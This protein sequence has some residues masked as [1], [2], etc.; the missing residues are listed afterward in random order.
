[1]KQTL[2]F[3]KT[4]IQGAC[5]GVLL[6]MTGHAMPAAAQGAEVVTIGTGATA[7]ANTPFGNSKAKAWTQSIYNASNFDLPAGGV[8]SA[9]A[10]QSKAVPA[11]FVAP[12]ITIYM[13]TTTMD[14]TSTKSDW[15]PMSDLT[16][17]YSG[18]EAQPLAAGWHTIELDTPYDYNGMENLVIAVLRDG[19]SASSSMNYGFTNMS[20]KTGV[21]M[22]M[23]DATGH[24]GTAAANTRN[25]MLANIKITVTPNAGCRPPLNLVTGLETRTSVELKWSKPEESIP[26]AYHIEYGEEGFV[27]GTGVTTVTADTTVTLRGLQPTQ[28]YDAYVRSICG[29]GDTSFAPASI[30]F[31]TVCTPQD[32]PYSDDFTSCDAYPTYHPAN[33]LPMCWAFPNLSATESDYPKIYVSNGRYLMMQT[34]G[35][36]EPAVAVLPVMATSVENSVLSFNCVKGNDITAQYGYI[37]DPNDASSFVPLGTISQE[38]YHRIDLEEDFETIPYGARLAFRAVPTSGA[39]TFLAFYSVA[40]DPSPACKMPIQAAI[41]SSHLE[42]RS[43]RFTWSGLQNQGETY[44]VRYVVIGQTD[45]TTVTG[46]HAQNYQAEGL[47]SGYNYVFYI[48]KL[49]EGAYTDADTVYAA[50]LGLVRV[51][52]GQPDWG[53]VVGPEYGTIGDMSTQRAYAYPHYHFKSWSDGRTDNPRP[54]NYSNEITQNS[55]TAEFAPDTN[56]LTV[57]V[58][59]AAFGSVNTT[60][61]DYAYGS[62]VTLV[63]TPAPGY[64]FAGWSDGTLTA[65]YNYTVESDAVIT[66]YFCDET[67]VRIVGT[68]S[69]PSLGTIVTVPASGIVNPGETVTVMASL[70]DTTHYDFQWVPA[71]ANVS[72]SGM[73]RVAE[74]VAGTES[75]VVAGVLTPK[76]Y[77][78]TATVNEPTLGSVNGTGIYEYGSQV[79]LVAT[80]E[81]NVR[82]VQWR[83]SAFSN[84]N[85]LTVNVDGNKNLIANFERD[86]ITVVVNTSYAERGNVYLR[87]QG[88]PTSMRV[89]VGDT[90][91]LVATANTHYS[92]HN[93]SNSNTAPTQIIT[94]WGS[95][96]STRTYTAYF[97]PDMMEISAVANMRTW[98][99]V[100]GTAVYGYGSNAFL[101]AT[102]YDHY[103]F[104]RWDDGSTD[105]PYRPLVTG[106][107]TYTAIFGAEALSI[108]AGVD[109]PLHGS[110]AVSGEIYYSGT[111]TLT[112][113]TLD[114]WSFKAWVNSAGD[115]VSRSRIYTYQAFEDAYFKACFYKT[116]YHVLVTATPGMG[117]IVGGDIEGDYKFGDPIH[118]V[119]RLLDSL[120]YEFVGWSHSGDTSAVLDYSVDSSLTITA[121]YREKDQYNLTISS[122][123]TA[124][125]TVSTDRTSYYP[126]EVAIIRATPAPHYRFV[127]WSDGTADSALNLRIIT[128]TESLTLTAIFA[129]ERYGLSVEVNDRNKGYVTG[130]GM[131]EYNTDAVLTAVAFEGQYF[132]GWNGQPSSMPT[133]TVH[134]TGDT[135]VTASFATTNVDIQVSGIFA[136]TTGSGTYPYGDSVVISA[137]PNTHYEFSHWGDGSTFNPR[138]IVVDSTEN[139]IAHC[140][141]RRYTI[142]GTPNEPSFGYV[143]GSDTRPYG[144][145]ASR[146]EAFANPHCHFLRWSDGVITASRVIT[147]DTNV[148]Y[149]AIFVRD[150]FNVQL[151]DADPDY[152]SVNTAVNG[153]YVYDTRLLLLATPNQGVQFASWSDGDTLNPR[154]IVVSE[155]ITGLTAYFDSADYRIDTATNDN[156]KG[157]ITL[158]PAKSFYRYGETVDV[159]YV[160]HDTNLYRFV[161]WEDGTTAPVRTVSMTED[162]SVMAIF[163]EADKYSV[164]VVSSDPTLGE[165][166]GS[167]YSVDNGTT[168][169]VIARPAPH[170]HFLRWSDNGSTD[171]VRTI[172]LNGADFIAV[173]LFAQDSVSIQVNVSHPERG[174]VAGIANG[175]PLSLPYGSE[176][177]LLAVGNTNC[178]FE[179][180]SNGVAGENY[181]FTLTQDTVLT[182]NFS[183]DLF[184]TAVPSDAAMGSVLVDPLQNV[185]SYNESVT[186]TARTSDTARYRFVAWSDGVSDSVR[187]LTLTENVHLVALFTEVNQY[188]VAAVSA[189]S[190][191]GTV[192][193]SATTVYPGTEVT[194]E[195][196]PSQHGRFLRWS[197]GSTDALRTVTV[198]SD[199]ILIAFFDVDRYTVS[200]EGGHA[201]LFGAGTF[202]YGD[203]VTVC[204]FP[205]QGY[206]FRSWHDIYGTLLSTDPCYTFLPEEDVTL[207]AFTEA[208]DVRYTVTAQAYP[209]NTG[210]VLVTIAGATTN[211]GHFGDTVFVVAQAHDGYAFGY[212][213]SNSLPWAAHIANETFSFV[214]TEDVTLEA[215]FI[216]SVGIDDVEQDGVRIRTEA[217]ILHVEGAEGRSVRVFDAVGRLVVSHAAVAPHLQTVLPGTGVYLVQVGSDTPRRITVIR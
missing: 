56:T 27:R 76:K 42:A 192:S 173:A 211:S 140:S 34:K 21:F 178:P 133:L 92:F 144:S 175:I 148:A 114:G 79:T 169:T 147:W 75:Q 138:T 78:V 65:T 83:G 5:L 193:C 117:E 170:C 89:A 153:R 84:A 2:K 150:S 87:T 130:A 113:D 168:H 154:I 127:K 214:L 85:P 11:T 146:L 179:G 73:V 132:E 31:T 52:S 180:W 210:R 217:N 206:I 86:S 195:A 62:Q 151:V 69:I 9:I 66:A 97:Q 55:F 107:K 128:M 185:Y 189:D 177:S 67:Q 95:N 80:P 181:T 213:T 101:E 216:A 72:S 23:N 126:G 99:A 100:D 199:T 24:P 81:R 188:V 162:R 142:T 194:L 16:E 207:M 124:W 197:D 77:Q 82:F 59:D 164:A 141:P 110:V 212:W 93:W 202:R 119:T 90:V 103:F 187:T 163:D 165:A 152:G 20:G 108:T 134:I 111:V 71:P 172:T 176:V 1:M 190:D 4:M 120:R 118:A 44:R 57:N 15:V 123:N 51:S 13:G 102:P 12:N 115:T 6:L 125:G 45:T 91:G 183:I 191:L 105:N 61:G 122:S 33:N 155:D 63:A 112:A 160:N 174:Y 149:T 182:A 60:G 22:M 161:A 166:L 28:R 159:S 186:L 98:G 201:T 19:A 68:L 204:A 43:V 37:I 53:Y 139:Y 96:G 157:H 26:V 7:N 94:A 156:L 3:V 145:Q 46:I 30:R 39:E 131:Y 17:V 54:F 167:A 106:N 40:V 137:T 129:P 36:S 47:V 198:T 171:T 14:V 35:G 38:T 41:D 29:D 10:F 205:D 184:L 88:G 48:D 49:C 70:T 74:V 104:I 203:S 18:N 50:T 158:S 215:H 121:V 116:N 109:D 8:I 136:T 32:L 209:L 135:T 25:A 64:T 208:E 143:T 200:L 58:N 196:T